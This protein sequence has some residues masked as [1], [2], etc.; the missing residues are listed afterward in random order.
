MSKEKIGLKWLWET[1]PAGIKIGL[2][3]S[4]VLASF[5]GVI[6]GLVFG[7]LVKVDY[8][9]LTA[10]LKFVSSALLAFIIVYVSSYCY[11]VLQQ[12]AVKI[13][14]IKLKRTFFETDL[15]KALADENSSSS[16]AVNKVASLSK[17]IEQQYFVPIFYMI[18]AILLGITS[19]FLVLKT[20]LVLGA[21]YLVLSFV[22]FLP[23]YSGKKALSQRT[24][25][26]SQKNT[27]LLASVTD[28]FRGRFDI[29]Y[30]GAKKKFLKK[31]SNDL[32]NEE[33]AYFKLNQLQF[34]IQTFAGLVAVVTLLLP[35]L[36]GLVF[37]NRGLFG[38]TISTIVTLSLTAD[39]VVGS[40][41]EVAYYH[42]EISGTE[43]I[44]AIEKTSN[45][46][47]DLISADHRSGDLKL[48]D[49]SVKRKG[50]EIFGHINLSVARGDKIVLTGPSGIG[51]STLLQAM[52]GQL[53]L[54]K[55]QV[56]FA[57]ERL[58][59]GDFAYI[60]QKVWTFQ[61]SIRE[62]LSLGQK[63]EDNEM[64]EVLDKVGLK[65]ELGQNILD[66]SVAEDGA[67]L[68]GGQAQRL[69]I[70]RGLLR[71]KQLFLFDEA[72]SSLDQEN[73]DLIH[74]LIYQLPATV[75]EVAHYYSTSLIR[76]YDVKV[77]ELTKEG[78]RLK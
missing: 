32:A 21:I 75:V 24:E 20:N 44:R 55:G 47:K 18:Q 65:K 34:L 7:Y 17:Q 19:T 33:R 13:M 11:L 25:D 8:H 42:A 36:I 38:I 40:V 53:P 74:E 72:T 31:F 43:S 68:S 49:V 77:Y 29:Y 63:Y 5:E 67:N 41:R 61:G 50:K 15:N 51:K 54:S 56:L 23:S 6:N 1:I 4:G 70:A 37:V 30:Y 58:K 69:A 78:L 22:S 64:L 10:I 57:G 45:S 62:N 76:K 3:L 26:W 52:I 28:I 73:A 14:N 48:I 66:V 39:R 16:E 27:I 71:H 60:S 35:I 12:H 46:M 9:D 59:P 2:L